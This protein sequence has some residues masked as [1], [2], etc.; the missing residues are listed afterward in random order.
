MWTA[1]TDNRHDRL[2]DIIHVDYKT[3]KESV[4]TLYHKKLALK[5]KVSVSINS[6]IDIRCI[7]TSFVTCEFKMRQDLN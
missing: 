1:E 6:S 4:F 7:L 3:N 5:I 2:N